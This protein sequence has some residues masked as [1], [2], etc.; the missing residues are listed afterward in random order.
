[1]LDSASSSPLFARSV[2]KLLPSSERTTRSSCSI[3]SKNRLNMWTCDLR[4]SSIW[5]SS[6]LYRQ[7]SL[8]RAHRPQA[9]EKTRKRPDAL[10]GARAESPARLLN[11]SATDG[12]DRQ[13][14]ACEQAF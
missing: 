14:H 2:L 4:I 3:F 11:R 10:H 12:R 6:H 9:A 5:S 13:L 1:M 8:N 7:N